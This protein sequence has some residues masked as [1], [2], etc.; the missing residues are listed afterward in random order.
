M[1][2]QKLIEYIKTNLDQ[3]FSSGQ[4][5]DHLI[6]SGWQSMDV[7]DAFH[8]VHTTTHPHKS[9]GGKLKIILIIVVILIL[10]PI[11]FIYSSAILFAIGIYAPPTGDQG[12]CSGFANIGCPTSWELVSTGD[13]NVILKNAAG[14]TITVEKIEVTISDVTATEN[15]IYTIEAGGERAY[16]PVGNGGEFSGQSGYYNAMIEVTYKMGTGT[17]EQRDTGT[18]SGSAV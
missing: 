16:H 5:R 14:Q 10:A 6:K 2:E 11:L 17:I 13:F 8:F 3:G 12:R 1:V 9:G 4:I 7:D 18:L 15:S